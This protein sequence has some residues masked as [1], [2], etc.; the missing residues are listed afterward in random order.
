MTLSLFFAGVPLR[1][2]HES[3]FLSC[4]PEYLKHALLV[5]AVK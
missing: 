2:A 4:I 3:P 1:L 5:V